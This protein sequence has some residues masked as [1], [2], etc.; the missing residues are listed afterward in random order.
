MGANVDFEKRP[1][2]SSFASF[3]PVSWPCARSGI[4]RGGGNGGGAGS[5]RALGIGIEPLEENEGV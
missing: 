1:F 3:Q 5:D 2:R 4:K